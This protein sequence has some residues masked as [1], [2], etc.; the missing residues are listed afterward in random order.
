MSVVSKLSHEEGEDIEERTDSKGA[1][2]TAV[3][4]CEGRGKGPPGWS[5]DC[6]VAEWQGRVGVSGQGTRR[7]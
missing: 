6:G 7:S 5:S 1:G 4:R 2:C 3:R